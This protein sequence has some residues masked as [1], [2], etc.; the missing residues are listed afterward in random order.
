MHKFAS[1][2]VK[3]ATRGKFQALYQKMCTLKLECVA[4]GI[5]ENILV[6]WKLCLWTQNHIIYDKAVMT[7]MVVAYLIERGDFSLQSNAIK[8]IRN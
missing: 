6:V 3:R 2:N 4:Y 7:S 1:S 5:C 8:H